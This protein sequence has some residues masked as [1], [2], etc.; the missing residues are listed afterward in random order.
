MNVRAFKRYRH[1]AVLVEAL[2]AIPVL[3]LISLAGVQY[4]QAV[5]VQQA[6]QAAADAAAREAAKPSLDPAPARVENVVNQ[7]LGRLG[8]A[9]APNAGVRIDLDARATPNSDTSQLPIPPG[10]DPARQPSITRVTVQVHYGST[11]LPNALAYFGI[12]FAQRGFRATAI[13]RRQ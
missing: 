10:P 8:L 12:D 9:V 6:V 7:Y 2:L 1:G 4:V 13:A 5:V 3:V 11:R